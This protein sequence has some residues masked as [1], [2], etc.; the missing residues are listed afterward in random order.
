MAMRKLLSKK[1]FNITNVA[2][3]SLMNCRISSSSLAVRTRVPNDST[4]TTKIAPEP[5]DLAMSRR[6]M[7]NSAMIRP[8][9]IMQMP[10][11]ESLIEKLREIDGS[12]DRIRLDGLAPPE[13][14]TSLTVADTKKLL[15]AAQIE[16]VKSKLRET[17]RSWMPYK[18]FVSVCGEASSDPDLG[19]KIA[20]MLDDSANVIVLGDSVCIRPDQ[21][22]SSFFFS[23]LL[24]F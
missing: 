23:S 21:V 13:R 11:G 7:H 18:E 3:Q 16:I 5:G 12:K 22:L 10:V 24:A 19:S 14:E 20:K 6:F 2:S 17:G 4:D 8:A 9:E 15:R 1:L